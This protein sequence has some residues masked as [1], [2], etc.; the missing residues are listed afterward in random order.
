MN[1]GLNERFAALPSMEAALEHLYALREEATAVEVGEHPLAQPPRDRVL[2]L[3][4]QIE[5]ALSTVEPMLVTDAVP[6]SMVPPLSQLRDQLP[7]H[8][9]GSPDGLEVYISPVADL[10]RSLVA[11]AGTAS[12][13]ALLDVERRLE[14]AVA[15]AKDEVEELGRK[16]SEL[17]E[18]IDRLTTTTAELVEQKSSELDELIHTGDKRIT[19]V[20]DTGRQ[21]YEADRTGLVKFGEETV[22]NAEETLA[23]LRRVLAIAGDESLSANYGKRADVEDQEATKLRNAA[24]GFGIAT[25]TAA[26]AGAAIQV[27]ASANGWDYGVWSS[28]PGK[29]AV[30][31]AFGAIAAYYGR[32]ASSHRTY[33][34]QLR[35]AQLELHNIGPYLAELDTEARAAVRTEL[36]PT[37]FGRATPSVQEDAPTTAASAEQ[38]LELARLL[39]K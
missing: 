36:V 8:L 28:L 4:A 38:L 26:L 39:A 1:D 17:V 37:F 14:Q 31:A 6:S 18:E 35:N 3:V 21:A 13:P 22:A 29:F 15:A 27:L 34:Q 10:A 30:I 5:G 9:P 32:Q 23:E 7:A 25:A 12:G 16:R 2:G 19:G 20:A 11:V 33:A 24:V